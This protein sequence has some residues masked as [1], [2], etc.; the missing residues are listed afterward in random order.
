[1]AKNTGNLNAGTDSLALARQD[2]YDMATDIGYRATGD[3]SPISVTGGNNKIVKTDASGNA[4]LTGGL[5]AGGKTLVEVSDANAFEVK[6]GSGNN[7]LVVDSVARRVKFYTEGTIGEINSSSCTELY[8]LAN[9]AIDYQISGAKKKFSSSFSRAPI[10][11][12]FEGSSS[13]GGNLQGYFGTDNNL[14]GSNSGADF[15]WGSRNGANIW[16]ENMR[17][18]RN[19]VLNMA[20]IPTSA[21]GLSSGDIWSNAGVLNIIA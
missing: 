19:G 6:D 16:K 14:P 17:L 21:A 7:T 1:M 4:V 11:L 3:V 8:T 13:A 18:R 12:T 10:L 5:E 9:G 2:L 20:Y 15:V